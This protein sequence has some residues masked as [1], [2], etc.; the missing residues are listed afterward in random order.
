MPPLNTERKHIVPVEQAGPSRSLSTISRQDG[1]N[2]DLQQ[3]GISNLKLSINAQTAC[4]KQFER[5]PG[6][7]QTL[8]A[9]L[10]AMPALQ[11]AL[12]VFLLA[13]LLLDSCYAVTD[14]V[15]SQDFRLAA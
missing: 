1:I 12:S 10:T 9:R 5:M 7:R 15:G 3:K 11:T 6:A 4:G 14:K 2:P 13:A 8:R